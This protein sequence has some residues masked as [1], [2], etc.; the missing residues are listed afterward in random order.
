MR[1]VLKWLPALI[2]LW[3]L[4]SRRTRRLCSIASKRPKRNSTLART[5]RL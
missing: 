3:P 2:V 1:K 5:R 4:G